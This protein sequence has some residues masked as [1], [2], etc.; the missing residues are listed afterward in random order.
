[1]TPLKVISFNMQFGQIWDPENPDSAPVDISQT[2]EAIRQADAD[3]VFLQEVEQVDPN[4]IQ[5]QPPP[6]FTFLKNALSDYHTHFSYPAFD[7]RELPFGFG[8]A[9]FSKL[10]LH[11][12]TIHHLP[13]PDIVFNFMGTPTSPTGRLLIGARATFQG[14]EIQLFNTHLQ[15]FFII[16][17]TSDQHPAQRDE[18]KRILASSTL[19]TLIGGDFNTAPGESTVSEIQSIGYKTVQESAIT[20]KRMPFVLD[21]L[22]YNEGWRLIDHSVL[23]TDASDHDIL[24][25]R[26]SLTE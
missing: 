11:D 24:Q 9:I 17:H 2:L 6:N 8:L 18:V 21:H 4:V 13:A 25:A 12:L 1:M 10:P 22:F 23:P 7:S 14:R 3:V 16:N 19:P 5:L 26:F 20:W 15:A